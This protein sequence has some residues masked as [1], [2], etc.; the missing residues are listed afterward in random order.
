M[1]ILL[2]VY[3]I[4]APVSNIAKA[5]LAA[6]VQTSLGKADTAAQPADVTA[7]ING[8]VNAAP[9]QLDT[10]KELS[11]ALGGDNNFAASV[12]ASLAGKAPATNIAKSALASAVQASLDRADNAAVA[13]TTTAAL[14]GKAD[15]LSG[16]AANPNGTVTAN[17]GTLYK[18]DAGTPGQVMWFK[19]T[20]TGSDGWVAIA[21][22]S[23]GGAGVLQPFVPEDTTSAGALTA[24]NLYGTAH[25][26]DRKIT[27]SNFLIA[28]ST[29]MV[30]GTLFR[31]GL[32]VINADGTET[33]V[34]R[35]SGGR[36]PIVGPRRSRVAIVEAQSISHP[37]TGWW[38]WVQWAAYAPAS[39]RPPRPV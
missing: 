15:V 12:T 10:L 7:A 20:G 11:D 38:V 39:G 32:Y 4:Y 23:V 24:G 22:S 18:S 21:H 2:E 28:I 13:S 3:G 5:A 35:S 17:P 19:E 14:A 6:A 9:S 27:V 25:I 16:S 36:S 29:A 37:S 26:A 34:A 8:L 1:F 30:G 31:C 33:L